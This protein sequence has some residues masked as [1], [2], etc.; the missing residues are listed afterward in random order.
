MAN[1]SAST[2]KNKGTNYN[3]AY[4]WANLSLEYMND[5]I[6]YDDNTAEQGKRTIDEFVNKGIAIS[7][8]NVDTDEQMKYYIQNASKLRC[9]CTNYPKTLLD[10]MGK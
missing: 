9:I 7:V 8:Y 2:Y 10:K 1:E 5:G 6:L 4:H 3:Y